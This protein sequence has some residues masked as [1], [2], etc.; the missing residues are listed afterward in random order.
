MKNF[1]ILLLLCA[2]VFIGG[3]FSSCKKYEDGPK[4]SLLSVKN[5]ISRDWTLTNLTKNG[6]NQNIEGYNQFFS[7][8]KSGSYNQTVTVQTVWGPLTASET[9]DWKFSAD[10][11]N[12]ILTK[13][14]ETTSNSYKILELRKSQMKVSYQE[15][16]DEY[17]RTF[18]S[19]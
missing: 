19:K 17:T 6:E 14:G 10:K 4:I 5:R 1:R 7:F 8:A 12:V 3:T 18:Q 2:I 15:N 16:G 9:G 13:T 11:K